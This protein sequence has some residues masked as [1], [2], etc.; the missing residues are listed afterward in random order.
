MKPPV[1]SEGQQVVAVKSYSGRYGSLEKGRLYIIAYPEYKVDA[2][3][4]WPE[5]ITD[6]WQ[7]EYF[8]P[9]E[10]LSDECLAKLLAETLEVIPA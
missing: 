9:A 1:F 4:Y 6:G 8:A 3:Y 7:A 2:W 5:G 10:P